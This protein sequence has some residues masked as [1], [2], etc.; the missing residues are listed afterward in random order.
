MAGGVPFFMGKVLHYSKN[1]T[2]HEDG[3]GNWTKEMFIQRFRLATKPFPV[4]EEE[5]SEM[6]WVEFSG[7][8]DEDLGAIWDYLATPGAEGTHF[9]G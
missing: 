3:M 6:N 7:M 1:L 2:P 5:N 4:A 9:A 8:S